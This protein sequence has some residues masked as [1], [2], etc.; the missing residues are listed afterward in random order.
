MNLY[1]QYIK[2]REN[3]EI[4][5][6]EHGFATYRKIDNFN[7]YL[8][9]MFVEKAFRKCNI[10]WDLNNIVCDIAKKDGATTLITS[11]CLDAVGVSTSMSV[12][13]AGGFKYTSSEGN[14]LYFS[15]PL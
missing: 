5:I 10:A 11:I 4:V 7:Y 14:M 2:E 15:K 12:I 1:A 9:D 8:I 13:L 6:L 3:S